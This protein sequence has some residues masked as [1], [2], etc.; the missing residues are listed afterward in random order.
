MLEILFELF[1]EF[2][3][4]FL[5]EILAVFGPHKWA[6][7]LRRP[8]E[9]WMTASYFAIFGM[10]AGGMSLLIVHAHFITHK[11][12]RIVN[13]IVTPLA[14]GAAMSFIGAWR[15]RHD[16]AMLR[17]DRFSY[18]YLFALGFAFIRFRFAL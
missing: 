16:E 2:I 5:F 6:T 11:P 10:L 1:G 12:T 14:I 17:F 9:A 18:G 4:Q 15:E 7:S 8:S 3:L 13:L